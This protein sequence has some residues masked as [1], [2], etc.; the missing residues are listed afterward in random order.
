MLTLWKQRSPLPSFI[1]CWDLAVEVLIS[2]EG[3]DEV[4]LDAL[5]ASLREIENYADVLGLWDDRTATKWMR[6]I[7]MKRLGN[8]TAHADALREVRLDI[9]ARRLLIEDPL[10]R[11][12]LGAHF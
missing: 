6:C 4:V 3:R 5:V 8:I 12:R 7:A 9:E 11:A 10:M 2:E 1:Q